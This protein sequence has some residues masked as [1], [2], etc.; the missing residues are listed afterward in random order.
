MPPTFREA[1][2]HGSRDPWEYE[3]GSAVNNLVLVFC[4]YPWGCKLVPESPRTRMPSSCLATTRVSESQA[5]LSGRP[6][7]SGSQV[8]ANGPTLH[9]RGIARRIESMARS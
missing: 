1:G 2:V 4:R 9:Q 7:R 6:P 5:P 8:P 3:K